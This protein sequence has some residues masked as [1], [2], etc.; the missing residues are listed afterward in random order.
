MKSKEPK[1][2]KIIFSRNMIAL[3]MNIRWFTGNF[4]NK[5]NHL[6]LQRWLITTLHKL[7]WPREIELQKN[8]DVV[9]HHCC[10]IRYKWQHPG[11]LH[12]C[13]CGYVAKDYLQ[14]MKLCYWPLPVRWK[15]YNCAVWTYALAKD[16]VTVCLFI[17]PV[18]VSHTIISLGA[19][20]L[21]HLYCE[22][23]EIKP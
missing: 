20:I 11:K 23:N 1:P 5:T 14:D 18:K 9:R 2:V 13:C 8:D 17:F 19:L 7:I 16:T 12:S 21:V 15:I 4:K 22:M 3:S 6:F 10:I